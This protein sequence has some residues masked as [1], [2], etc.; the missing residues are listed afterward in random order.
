MGMRVASLLVHALV[1][2]TFLFYFGTG[3]WPMLV[4][5]FFHILFFMNDPACYQNHCKAPSAEAE[6]CEMCGMARWRRMRHCYK[7]ERCIHKYDHHCFL[8][9]SCVGEFNHKYYMFFLYAYTANT[10][11]ML[12][13]MQTMIQPTVTLSHTTGIETV[14]R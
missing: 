5:P 1:V 9:G 6:T 2:G 8:M 7:C 4:A 11:A 13:E 3:Y 14:S 10:V 12:L